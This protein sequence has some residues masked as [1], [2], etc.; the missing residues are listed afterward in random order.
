MKYILTNVEDLLE[1]AVKTLLYVVF[2]KVLKN[3]H[4]RISVKKSFCTCRPGQNARRASMKLR[5][6]VCGRCMW[7]SSSMGPWLMYFITAE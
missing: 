5:E 3:M 7:T 1:N 4:S 6:L 2:T